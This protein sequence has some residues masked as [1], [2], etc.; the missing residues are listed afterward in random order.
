[1]K[2]RNAGSKGRSKLFTCVGCAVILLYVLY[3]SYSPEETSRISFYYRLSDQFWPRDLEKD[4]IELFLHPDDNNA[5]PSDWEENQAKLEGHASHSKDPPTQAPRAELN[6]LL[7]YVNMLIGTA[8]SPHHWGQVSSEGHVWVGSARPF[9]LVKSGADSQY[10]PGGYSNHAAIS[11]ITLTHCSGIGAGNSYQVIALRPFVGGPEELKAY[12]LKQ[13]HADKRSLED[14]LDMKTLRDNQVQSPGFFGVD[15]VDLGLRVE[16]V[17]TGRGAIHSYTRSAKVMDLHQVTFLVDISRGSVSYGERNLQQCAVK[18]TRNEEKKAVQI[19]GYGKYRETWSRDYYT[20]FFCLVPR[21]FP[22]AAGIFDGTA[23]V[24]GSANATRTKPY[25]GAYFTYNVDDIAA[26]E[27]IGAYDLGVSYISTQ[28][29]CENRKRE[30][31]GKS[32]SEVKRDGD[33]EW[34]DVLN[35]IVVEGPERAKRIFYSSLYRIFLMPINQTAE[36]PRWK[37]T[38]YWNDFYTLWDTFRTLLPMY[39]LIRPDVTSSIVNSLLDSYLH[40]GFLPDS[41]VAGANGLTQ[42]GSN[43]AVVIAD[44]FVKQI[45]GVNWTIAFDAVRN[46]A[47]MNP[48]NFMNSGRDNTDW[49]TLGY[50]P[51]YVQCPY[52]KVDMDERKWRCKRTIS[53][54]TEYAHNDYNVYTLAKGLDKEPAVTGKFLNRSSYW[55]NLWD[56]DLTDLNV[57]GFLQP[58]TKQGTFSRLDP[59]HC[60]PQRSGFDCFMES[61]TYEDSVW[62][63][64][65]FVPQDIYGLIEKCGGAKAFEQRLNVYFGRNFFIAANEPGFLIPFLYHY[66]GLPEKS[67]SRVLQI[68]HDNYADNIGGIPGNDDAGA[69][70]SFYLFCSL[71]FFPVAGQDLYLIVSPLFDKSTIFLGSDRSVS[72]TIIAHDRSESNKYVQSAKLFGNTLNRAWFHHTEILNAG[73]GVLELF[74]GPKPGDWG[75]KELPPNGV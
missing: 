53:R 30:V 18:L 65:F 3:I 59:Q 67:V 17:S 1:M 57:K 44:A 43:A 46:D 68:L 2:K 26:H 29:A 4:G 11:T 10:S 58:R 16:M 33:A 50:V 64:S 54:T 32:A 52:A 62:T 51:T 34:N 56:K 75:R 20:L 47:E 40:E 25:L 14:M 71:G 6:D 48:P 37:S 24:D 21:T 69:L 9:G 35:L 36:N 45:P 5:D 28:R 23:V 15:L 12:L 72:F 60:T 38:H 39:S 22:V 13:S 49:A 73:G 19:T 70:G 7:P 27:L 66:I 31:A 55:K 63:Y 74:M 41:R 61:E 8:A 42:G